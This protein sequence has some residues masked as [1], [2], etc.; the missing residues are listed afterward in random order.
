MNGQTAV[1]VLLL[2]GAVAAGMPAAPTDVNEAPLADAGLDQS[3]SQGSAVLLD[4]GGSRDPDGEIASYSWNITAPGGSSVAPDCGTCERPQFVATQPGIYEVTL[5]VTDDDGATSSDTL[6]VT[7]GSGSGLS[8]TLSGPDAT[9]VTRTVHYDATVDGS[10]ATLQKLVWRVNGTVVR[11]DNLDGHG[12][13]ERLPY[14]FTETGTAN[15]SVTAFDDAG[16]VATDDLSVS[17]T[18]PNPTDPNDPPNAF[19]QGPN[20]VTPDT[21]VTFVLDATDPDNDTLSVSWSNVDTGSS[22]AAT[23]SFNGYSAGDTVTITAEVSDGNGGTVTASKTVQVVPSGNNNVGGGP[24]TNEPPTASIG[25]PSTITE[26]E[27]GNFQVS[28]NDPDGTVVDIAW[29]NVYD[30]GIDDPITVTREF[31]ST[32]NVTISVTVTDDD[33]ATTTVKHTVRVVNPATP[34]PTSTGTS[35]ATST[36]EPI[37][38][39]D[40]EVTVLGAHTN[41]GKEKRKSGD[42]VWGATVPE[43]TNTLTLVVSATSGGA[44][45]GTAIHINLAFGDGTSARTT[46]IV[47]EDGTLPTLETGH[48]FPDIKETTTFTV[49][50]TA[51]YDGETGGGMSKSV[52]FTPNNDGVRGLKKYGVA[53]TGPEKAEPGQTS[54]TVLSPTKYR[55]PPKVV[56]YYGDGSK[57]VLDPSDTGEFSERVTHKYEQQGTYVASAVVAGHSSNAQ[58]NNDEHELKVKHETY[59]IWEYNTVGTEYTTRTTV[60]AGKPGP[61]WQWVKVVHTDTEKV[62][63]FSQPAAL[64]DPVANDPYHWYFDK[65]WYNSLTD[66]MWE[67]W[68]KKKV[69]SYSKWKIYA[70]KYV[71]GPV[72][73]SMS[74]PADHKVWKNTAKRMTFSCGNSDAPGWAR[75]CTDQNG[76]G[77]V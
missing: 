23:K 53:L 77:E 16:N 1:V 25:G 13:T 45:P 72:G 15:V 7:V 5:T 57:K 12:T 69:V 70:K 30:S 36:P 50:A 22:T 62:K 24:P 54:L 46:L 44:P 27:W 71:K 26:G 19:I 31:T 34:T 68:I 18:S 6:Y 67:D 3:V 63:T 47:Q 40:P 76:G 55:T 58:A 42:E 4:G 56:V 61:G 64:P 17:V 32:G 11:R 33:G 48:K 20:Q 29:S 41:L 73:Y 52:T 60:S 28:A 21:S 10:G 39:Y 65:S 43:T 49:S 66:S 38:S 59:T 75:A 8:V 37:E 51:S 9:T 74:K 35:T 14:T 2:V